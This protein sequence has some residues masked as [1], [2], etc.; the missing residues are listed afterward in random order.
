MNRMRKM[1]CRSKHQPLHNLKVP[2]RTRSGSLHLLHHMR[3]CLPAIRVHC[4]SDRKVVSFRFN[5][6]KGEIGRTC[7]ICANKYP[8]SEK[9]QDLHAHSSGFPG[10]QDLRKVRKLNT[11]WDHAR[12]WISTI[13]ADG[14]YNGGKLTRSRCT[15][16]RRIC[17]TS[18]GKSCARGGS[19]RGI[20]VGG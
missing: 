5:S 2:E 1:I 15:G 3:N 4:L 14:R 20:F 19:L 9:N 6:T 10:T 12:A 7:R 16:E 13:L 11:V 18:R 17:C 8:I